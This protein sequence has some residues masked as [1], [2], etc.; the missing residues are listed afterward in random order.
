V[1]GPDDRP[2]LAAERTVLAH[3]RTQLVVSVAVLLVVREATPGLE[4]LVAT[5]AAAAGGALVWLVTLGRERELRPGRRP[6]ALPRALG[7]RALAFVAGVGLV[8]FA[9]LVVTV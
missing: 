5:S 3:W 2:T 4:R 1:N 7:G 6:D 9:A 8:Q